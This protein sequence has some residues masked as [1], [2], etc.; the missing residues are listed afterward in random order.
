MSSSNLS[1]A[2]NA[3]GLRLLRH[4]T[5]TKP[6]QNLV[7]SPS[8]IITALVI[9][10]SGAQQQTAAELGAALGLGMTDAETALLACAI[11]ADEPQVTLRS[12]NGFWSTSELSPAF[13]SLCQRTVGAELQQ[14]GEPTETAQRINAWVSAQ[15]HGKINDLLQPADLVGAL[16]TLV[17]ALYFK[18]QWQRPFD[19][20]R[21]LLADFHPL[22][23]A[24]QP[25][26]FMQ[27]KSRL[28]I[29]QNDRYQ[30]VALPYGQGRFRMELFLPRQ[31]SPADLLNDELCQVHFSPHNVRLHLPRFSLESRLDLIPALQAMGIQAAFG[32]TADFSGMLPTPGV[33]INRAVQKARLEVNEQ[34][35]EAAAATAIVMK[36][37][38]APDQPLELNFDHPF[39]C[40]LRDTHTD[41]IL[42][43]ALIFDPLE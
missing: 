31:G 13:V 32:P 18:G 2:W 14:M 40:Q 23:A 20:Q 6:D 37:G 4:W 25:R 8:S 42:F 36:R 12:A 34:G 38:A 43:Q 41:L 24:P 11:T 39:A 33:F 30:A 29:L 7:F 28:P 35:S 10:W 22:D 15:T 1:L 21:T 3:F 27:Q 9:A 26:P 16:L 5:Q 19:P 17:N